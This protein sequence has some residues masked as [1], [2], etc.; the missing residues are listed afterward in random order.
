MSTRAPQAGEQLLVVSPHLDD[1]VLSLGATLAHLA[2]RGVDVRVLTVLG[3]DPD[4]DRPAGASN[5]R[6][7]F[8]TTGEAARTRRAEDDLA[9]ARLGVRPLRLPFDDD[10]SAPRDPQALTAALA[11]SVRAADVVLVPGSPL[12]HPDHL[13][14]ARLAAACRAPAAAPGLY[15]E[16]PY[17]AWHALART[18]GR[19]W[20]TAVPDAPAVLPAADDAAGWER[21]GACPRCQ[22]RKV[23]AEAAYGS[24]L[25]VLRR[26]PRARIAV[27]EL[28]ARGERVA[29]PSRTGRS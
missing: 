4:T 5:R 8:T 24:Q 16:Q 3:G 28:L 21:S 6:A 9:C 18:G 15:L 10:E 27:H 25:R 7:G 13:L 23:A 29:W 11:P 20:R 26:W 22:R 17:A 14:V 12:T 1:A 19:P 2:R